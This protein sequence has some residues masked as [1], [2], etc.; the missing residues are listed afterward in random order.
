MVRIRKSFELYKRLRI[1][2]G[3]PTPVTLVQW[4]TAYGTPIVASAFNA[5]FRD[6]GDEFIN[7]RAKKRELEG[8]IKYVNTKEV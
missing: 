7:L 6:F 5:V 3:N 4:E 1:L 8:L 2:I